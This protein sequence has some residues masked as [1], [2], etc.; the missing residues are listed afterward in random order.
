MGGT[1]RPVVGDFD[2]DGAD[3]ILWYAPDGADSPIWWGR[4]G[5]YR[6]GRITN[7]S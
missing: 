1:Y 4:A 7:V 6:D 5:G 3:D 2:G